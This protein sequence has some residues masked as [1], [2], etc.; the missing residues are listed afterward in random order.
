M[1]H[2]CPRNV[3]GHPWLEEPAQSPCRNDGR[4]EQPTEV[5]RDRA[6]C[7]RVGVRRR[8]TDS[9]TDSFSV[10]KATGAGSAAVSFAK[11]KVI[12]TIAAARRGVR[13]RT[14][15]QPRRTASADGGSVIPQSKRGRRHLIVLT[16]RT[17]EVEVTQAFNTDVIGVRRS[18]LGY[19][20]CPKHFRVRRRRPRLRWDAIP[21]VGRC[22]LL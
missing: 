14:E 12:D 6:T 3:C 9:A 15:R 1:R 16:W 13:S 21:R 2:A 7:H 22:R 4:E 11:V 20:S 8:V 17:R 19:R 10:T 18:T 5:P